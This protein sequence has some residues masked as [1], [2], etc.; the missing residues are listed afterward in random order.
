MPAQ[1]M[2]DYTRNMAAGRKVSEMRKQL[3][4]LEKKVG[5]LEKG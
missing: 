5:E 1:P 4:D 2:A 3:R